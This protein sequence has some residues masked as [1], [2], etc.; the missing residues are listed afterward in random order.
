MPNSWNQNHCSTL[1]SSFSRRSNFRSNRFEISKVSLRIFNSRP[2]S[3]IYNNSFDYRAFT[4]YWQFAS[5]VLLR[6]IRSQ[7]ELFRTFAYK[8]LPSFTSN[9]NNCVCV[10][11]EICIARTTRKK[12]AGIFKYLIIFSANCC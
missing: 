6:W 3:K 11:T 5:C 8:F 1:V 4:V 2:V 12:Y 9:N 10:V 7:F